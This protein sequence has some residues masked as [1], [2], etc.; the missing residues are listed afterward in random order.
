MEFLWRGAI[1][2]RARKVAAKTFS[3]SCA[4][5]LSLARSLARFLLAFLDF[6]SKRRVAETSL[7]A[8]LAGP[9]LEAAL[10]KK[11]GPKK[12]GR[13]IRRVKAG[14]RAGSTLTHR[15]RR[16]GNTTAGRGA[17]S[18]VKE[19]A[20]GL[21]PRRRWTQGGGKRERERERL[22]GDA[23]QSRSHGLSLCSPARSAMLIS[24]L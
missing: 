17:K 23:R 16:E 24:L 2:R 22:P 7:W 19:R 20:N 12:E 15:T 10:A 13:K 18:K 14:A 11:R 6:C 4:F 5:F 1:M 21:A 8:G 3:P 9:P